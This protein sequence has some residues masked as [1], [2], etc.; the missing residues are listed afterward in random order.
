LAAAL[1]GHQAE[2]LGLVLALVLARAVQAVQAVQKGTCSVMWAAVW[3]PVSVL[4]LG[5]R[6]FHFACNK[7]NPGLAGKYHSPQPCNNSND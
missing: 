2:L 3:A 1:K 5:T 6:G 7:C 4:R